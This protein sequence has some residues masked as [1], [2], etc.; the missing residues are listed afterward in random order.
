MKQ[1]IGKQSIGLAGQESRLTPFED[2]L[3][4]STMLRIALDGR[5]V[6]AYILTKG[7][8][9][10]KFCFVFGF[11]CK[12]IHTTLRKEQID[13]IFNNI[14]SGLKDIPEGERMTLHMGSFS[15]DQ[16]RQIELT[17]LI[18]RTPSRD[19]KYLLMAERARAQELTAAGIRKPKF[20]KIYVT[21]TIEPSS[22]NAN[23]WIEKLLGKA[24]GWWLKFKGDIAE[25]ENQ[26]IESVIAKAYQQGFCRWE[27]LLS[28]KMGLD[29][30]P[31]NAVELWENVWRRFNDTQPIEIPQLVTLDENGLY[32]QAH[33]DL[34]S[35]Q[36]LIENVHSTTL[37]ME[38]G[39]PCADRRWVNVNNNY[40]GA[41]T[42]LEKP[43]GWP[44][45]FAQLR[46]LWELL[47]RESIVD[48]EIVCQLT[49]A[50]PALVKTTLQR[51]L[52]QSNM[53]A[54]LAQEKSKTIDVN[55]QLK[56]R[57]SV[58]AQEQLFEGAVPIYTGLAIFVHRP[59]V[60][61]LD[62]AT[63][64][65]ENC[66][67][68]PARVVRETEYAWKIWLQSLPIVWEGLLVKPFNRRQLYLTSEV[69]GLMPLVITKAGDK[70]GFEL[71][72]EEGG[73]P[74]QLDLFN[75][76][77]NLALFATTRAGKSVLVSGIL[78]QALAHGIPVVAL[79][80]PKPDGTS[81]FTDYA[82]F[83]EG[84]GAYFDIS[85]QSNNLF[86]QP[87]LRS[88]DPEQQRDRLLDYTGFLESALMTMVLGSSNDNQLLTQTVRSLLNLALSAFFADQGIQERYKMAIAGGFGTP[89][90]QKTPTLH[91]F[92]H[93]C[94]PEHLQLD[95]VSGRVEDALSQIH[96]RL[97]F[98][99][100][101]RVGQAISA[102]SS[103]PTDAQLLVFALR[104]LSDN[105][106]AAV[107]SLSAY[108]AALRRALSS[109][110]SIFFIDEAP[111]LFEFDQ[112]SDLVGR[113][114]ANGAKAGIRVIL[115]AQDP[116]TIAKSK[117]SSKIL[118]NLTTRLIGRI[119]PVAVDSF[120]SILK[121]PREI[122]A[123]NASESFFPRKEGVYS[124]WLL[125]DN[126]IH[127]FCRY[128]PGY[129]QLAVVANNPNEQTARQ[130]AMQDYRNKYE[131]ISVFARQ[132]V[133]S[134]RSS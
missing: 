55:A 82:H 99:L 128:Y 76:H 95:S 21:Y 43:G 24:E 16:Q 50:N 115:S 64:Y 53:T 91:D 25:V 72:A 56:L 66:F 70:H 23:D 85:R 6:G 122:I 106:D 61:K 19:I 14:E 112:I 133:A 87:D 58:A 74:V 83:M 102:P 130:Q 60:E 18:R 4:L 40:I 105:E 34:S 20:L 3:H 78:T 54:M 131:A 127:T 36:L 116:D 124:Q 67:Q 22:T 109:P 51:V 26:R 77:K 65:I 13:T 96:L 5:D 97:R 30:K 38:S 110:A 108:S 125:D 52:K 71:I 86:E 100:S 92:L 73:T 120:V 31:L 48:T 114:C 79:D 98:W 88:L 42:F 1:K 118:Q 8:Q 32:E 37:L 28:N 62:E 121:Y 59:T 63:R 81:T 69:P 75:Q 104:N 107:L 27:Q 35:T 123:R 113:M 101:S 45:K 80:F 47:A 134:L 44:N 10:D 11:E 94:S 111:I 46:Y 7:T 68:R 49:A 117:A 132:L 12:G 90:W 84:N 103:F 15:S 89:A 126:G 93:F 39:V 17:D 57:K 9:K 29:I 33:S 2:A 129:E 119:Q 41:M